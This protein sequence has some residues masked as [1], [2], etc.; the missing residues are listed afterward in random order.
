MAEEA[1]GNL[2]IV[3]Y[4][5]PVLRQRAAPVRHVTDDVRALVER[6][7]AVMHEAHGLGLAANQ[8]GIPRRVAV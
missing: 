6:M 5:D 4:G 1:G 8:V 7:V 2:K 3:K